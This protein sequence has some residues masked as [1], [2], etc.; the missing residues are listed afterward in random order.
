VSADQ[1]HD[2]CYGRTIALSV[3]DTELGHWVTGSLGHLGHLFR[4]GQ[5]VITVTRCA[6]RI[7]VLHK[8]EPQIT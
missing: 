6:T 2:L 5:W 7:S 3:P 1:F 4:L 8:V